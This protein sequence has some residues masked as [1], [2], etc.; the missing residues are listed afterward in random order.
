MHWMVGNLV[1]LDAYYNLVNIVTC[2]YNLTRYLLNLL[3]EEI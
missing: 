2:H 3:F 1:H